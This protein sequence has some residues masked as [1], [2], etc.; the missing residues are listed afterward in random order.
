MTKSKA[1]RGTSREV[2]TVQKDGRDLLVPDFPEPPQMQSLRRAVSTLRDDL[3]HGTAGRMRDHSPHTE[4]R[5]LSQQRGRTTPPAIK[6]KRAS[7]HPVPLHTAL[8]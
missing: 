3:K 1:M 2:F 4:T 5:Q 7:T 6:S 8:R